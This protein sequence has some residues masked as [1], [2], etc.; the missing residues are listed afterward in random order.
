MNI[1]YILKK[2]FRGLH[3]YKSSVLCRWKWLHVYTFEK[4]SN[5]SLVYWWYYY[6]V[7][8]EVTIF[9]GLNHNNFLTL[10]PVLFMY[11][12]LSSP[13]IH[14]PHCHYALLLPF[15]FYFLAITINP[16]CCSHSLVK[17][18]SLSLSPHT[19]TYSLSLSRSL[20]LAQP[21]SNRTGS[22]AHTYSLAPSL[23]YSFLFASIENPSKRAII[24]LLV[25]LERVN[26]NDLLLYI[27]F[28]TKG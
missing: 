15:K 6:H 16:I 10:C 20:S 24:H 26:P 2:W 7:A 13:L 23:N 5:S 12:C 25:Y 8:T 9:L 27:A 17:S 22:L 14:I 4:P 19:Y 28:I 3:C 21:S 11:F 1:D 18:L